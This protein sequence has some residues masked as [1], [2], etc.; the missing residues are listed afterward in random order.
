MGAQG[1]VL[2]AAAV[3]K[4]FSGRALAARPALLDGYA[5]ASWSLGDQLKV[6]FAFTVE[7]GRVLEIEMLA[8]PDQLPRLDLAPD[9]G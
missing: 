4:T 1:E 3:A 9:A 7:D 6:V 8:D 2:G 5:A